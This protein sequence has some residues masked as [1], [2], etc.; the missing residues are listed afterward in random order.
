[1]GAMRLHLHATL[2]VFSLFLLL[3]A[4]GG[5]DSAD[6]DASASGGDADPTAA[7]A[8]SQGA[9]ADETAADADSSGTDPDADVQEG[10]ACGDTTCGSNDVCCFEFGED[11][12][13]VALG[14]CEGAAVSCTSPSHCGEDQHCCTNAAQLETSCV[15]ECNQIVICDTEDDCLNASHQCCPAGD[16]GVCSPFCI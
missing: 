16:F 7:D 14:D 13:C 12:I 6:V 11:P 4:C 1:M 2:A 9:D 3:A 15:D 5:G 10:V 8:S